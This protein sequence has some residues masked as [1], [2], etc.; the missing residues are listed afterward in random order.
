MDYPDFS[1]QWETNPQEITISGT[2]LSSCDVGDEVMLIEKLRDANNGL[3]FV[4]CTLLNIS[5]ERLAS[6]F[7]LANRMLDE[8]I[9]TTM[10]VGPE[11]ADDELYMESCAVIAYAATSAFEDIQHAMYEVEQTAEVD[12]PNPSWDLLA[13][14][15]IE[16]YGGASAACAAVALGMV[17]LLIRPD[18]V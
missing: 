16:G 11:L 10:E 7:S 13:K 18:E 5:G 9:K 12:D 6:Y 17:D 4:I 2:A 1:Q 14:Q 8:S 15:A 3:Y